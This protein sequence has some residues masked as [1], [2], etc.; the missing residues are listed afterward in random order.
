MNAFL[1]ILMKKNILGVPIF[2]FGPII[3]GYTTYMP[4]SQK[5]P[6]IYFKYMMYIPHIYLPCAG[7][8]KE[9]KSKKGTTP[10]IGRYNLPADDCC[11][12]WSRGGGSFSTGCG[13]GQ[14]CRR[15]SGLGAGCSQRTRRNYSPSVGIKVSRWDTL[16]GCWSHKASQSDLRV[17]KPRT[18]I[19]LSNRL[20]CFPLPLVM[21]FEA[22]RALSTGRFSISA[23]Q[24]VS[25]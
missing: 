24:P 5:I 4:F 12:E 20:L 22:F 13:S 9:A 11:T 23:H 3:Y 14:R 1:K 25:L 10:L 7:A 21:T 2:F 18:W 15:Q 19:R 16:R 8:D 17:K 6:H